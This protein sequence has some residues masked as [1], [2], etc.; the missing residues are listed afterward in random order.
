MRL[1]FASLVLSSCAAVGDGTAPIPEPVGEVRLLAGDLQF[2]EGPVWLPDEGALI[3]SDIPR[4]ELLRWTPDGGVELFRKCAKPNGNALSVDGRLLTCLHGDRRLIRWEADGSQVVLAERFDDKRLNSPNDLAVQS[5]GTIWF[6]DPPWG[7]TR[8]TEGKELDG[9]FVFRRD[10]DGALAVVLR[11]RAMPNGIALSPD[12]STL[13][14]ADTGGHPS[15]PDPELRDQPATVSAWAI[16]N[17]NELSAE[18]LWNVETR[19]DGMCIDERGFVYTTAQRG[20]VILS[21]TGAFVGEI[22][23]PESPANVCFG[24]ADGRTL[25]ITARTSL[26]AVEMSV[27]GLVTSKR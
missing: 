8:Q 9:H 6:T 5:D 21:P 1:L 26:F 14:V 18:P 24:G 22:A 16:G 19:S 25:F 27:A 2:T 20:I 13:Y 10:V 7:L 4:G 3:F 23:V 17:D 11:D 12:E 15:H